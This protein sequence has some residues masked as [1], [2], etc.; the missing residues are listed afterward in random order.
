M[1][2]E[3]PLYLDHASTSFPKAPGVAEA[4]IE[5]LTVGLG[6]PERG[7]HDAAARAGQLV[8]RVRA[9][10]ANT[11]GLGDARQVIFTPSSTF[12]INLAL[13]GTLRAKDHVITTS[14]A[15]NAMLR[16]LAYLRGQGC[17]VTVV[18]HSQVEAEIVET[19]LREIR[20]TTRW[21]ALP[22]ASN[23]T[24]S[25]FPVHAIAAAARAEGIQ[26]LLDASQTAGHV[27]IDVAQSGADLVAFG[28]HKGLLGPPGLGCLLVA[29]PAI[30]I[31]PLLHGGTGLQS[32]SLV[33][34]TLLPGSYEAGT[35]NVPAIAGFGAA[36]TY[37][38][39]AV[40]AGHFE[41]ARSLR[42]RCTERLAAIPGLRLHAAA[43]P[44]VPII[45]FTIDGQLPETTAAR[46]ADEHGVMTRAGLHCAPLAHE[47]LGT[48]PYGTVRASFGFRNDAEDV[49]R[50]SDG[51]AAL[52]IATR[53]GGRK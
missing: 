25:L 3:V 35:Q 47:A 23:V 18:R 2:V 48:L 34:D 45:A 6:S 15:H 46:L 13:R 16:T 41:A 9:Q 14:F 20:P 12:A 7:R 39:E 17:D 53:R 28:A 22:H 42:S 19:I 51:L 33:P 44:A 27:E 52:C 24:G 49:D 5:A 37:L 30:E 38:G 32:E 10:V 8:A 40:P 26:V 50:L 31:A 43:E 21:L 11:F 1:G 36:L 4:M 29:D